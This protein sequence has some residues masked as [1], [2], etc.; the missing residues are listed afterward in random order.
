MPKIFSKDEVYQGGINVPY[1]EPPGRSPLVASLVI[2]EWTFSFYVDGSMSIK[3]PPGREFPQLSAAFAPELV[4]AI[5]DLT[6]P[7]TGNPVLAT[8]DVNPSGAGY[9]YVG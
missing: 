2:L 3:T 6:S 8:Q 1:V 9:G 7:E 4:M 5:H